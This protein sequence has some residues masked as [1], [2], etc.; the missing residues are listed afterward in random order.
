M[1][2]A[3][4]VFEQHFLEH[5]A[6]VYRTLY[7]VLGDAQESEDL[8][9]EVFL[10]L[11][12]TL[13]KEE[14]NHPKAWLTQVAVRTALNSIRGRTRRIHRHD[15]AAKHTQSETTQQTEIALSVRKVLFEALPDQQ[16]HLL[17]LHAAGLLYEEIADLLG[18][19]RSSMSQLLFRA[20]R[21]FAS[22]YQEDRDL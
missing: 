20:K 12:D 3:I 10:R 15:Q 11:H 2:P 13:Q 4:S 16:A 17:M 8:A 9:Q 18:L 1:P 14:V 22:A 5:Y 21:A 19:Q 7:R 6:H